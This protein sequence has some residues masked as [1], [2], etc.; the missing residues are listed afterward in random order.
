[1][2]PGPTG[3]PDMGRASRL[4]PSPGRSPRLQLPWPQPCRGYQG[5]HQWEGSGRTRGALPRASAP[6]QQPQRLQDGFA[7]P[8]SEIMKI[9]LCT[10]LQTRRHNALVT[11]A[12]CL[13]RYCA[14]RRSLGL[15]YSC[16]SGNSGRPGWALRRIG[17]LLA[18]HCEVPLA[19]GLRRSNESHAG[20]KV[21]VGLGGR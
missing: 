10:C 8:G 5:S 4:P 6:L 14:G 16:H 7:F 19:V 9:A 17:G 12:L 20:R 1:M 3:G 18:C 15:D 13:R 21:G 11:P 2:G